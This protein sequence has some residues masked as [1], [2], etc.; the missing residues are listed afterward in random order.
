MSRAIYFLAN[1]AVRDRVAKLVASLP[2]MTRVEFKDPRRTLDQNAKMHAMIG[3]IAKQHQHA[4]RNLSVKQWKWLFMHLLGAESI[5]WLPSLADESEL[6]PVGTATRELSV[7]QC[8]DM[9][10][11]LYSKGAEWGVVWSEPAY[12]DPREAT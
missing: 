5:E 12:Q 10:E 3:D 2:D 11:L 6:V 4:G 9:I 1:A 8:R 7:A